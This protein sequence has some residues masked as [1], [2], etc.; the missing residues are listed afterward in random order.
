M[1]DQDLFRNV[2]VCMFVCM[3]VCMYIV[4]MLSFSDDLQVELSRSG[5]LDS[6]EPD[7]VCSLGSNPHELEVQAFPDCSQRIYSMQC[8][9]TD[10]VSIRP[11]PVAQLVEHSSTEGGF[12]SSCHSAPG[13]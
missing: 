10:I 7:L 11:V 13:L 4:V 9:H 12:K 6:K 8:Y 1:D 2:Y 3:C 5:G